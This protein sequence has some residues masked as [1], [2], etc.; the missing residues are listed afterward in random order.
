MVAISIPE[1][2]GPWPGV[3]IV[4]DALGMSSDLRHQ[5]NWLAS[6]GYLSAAP[7]LYHRG[8][9]VR[10]MFAIIR[11]AAARQGAV[12]DDLDATRAWL[13]GRGDCTGKIG[14]IGFCMGGGFALL[15]SAT[16]DYAASSVN[17]GGV[18]KDAVTLLARA[19]PVVGS[20]GARDISLR[21]AP[22][23]LDRALTVNGIEHDIKVYP[24]AGHSFLN[25]HDWAEAPAWGLVMARLSRSAYHEPSAADARQR[26]IAFFGAHLQP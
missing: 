21:A 2:A 20:Y 9:R 23:R 6:E 12:F 26:I 24:G 19:C 7:D 18:P 14:V 16:G 4:H 22:G 5:A 15:L 1:G 17:Y 11:Q 13:A 8:G 3:L 25:D 10:C